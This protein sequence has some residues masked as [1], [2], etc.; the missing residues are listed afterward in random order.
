M[1]ST[2][3]LVVPFVK[4]H[5]A[6]NDFIVIDNRFMHFTG[7]ELATI[8]LRFCPR[9]FGIG[10]D[11]LLALEKADEP[12]FNYRMRYY[13]ADGSVARM[14]GNGARCLARFAYHGGVEGTSMTDGISYRFQSDAGSYSADVSFNSQ[15]DIALHVP[16]PEGFREDMDT[17]DLGAIHYIWTGTEHAVVMVSD[18]AT[19]PVAEFGSEIR[20]AVAFAPE[21]ANAD[22]VQ[23]AADQGDTAHLLVRTFERGVEAETLA[24]GT[25]VLASAVVAAL[26]GLSTA[27]HYTVDVPGGRL[28]VDIAWREGADRRR[29]TI[30]DIE[31]LTLSGPAATVYQGTLEFSGE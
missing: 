18:V 5:G 22:F 7:A 20:H 6:G 26:T 2:Q 8:A 9:R 1:K 13:N 12:G 31:G 11:G 4:M 14:C 15:G 24:C 3:P 16:P 27:Q 21:G 30:E 28:G 17:C 25:G 10:A 19:V 23:V 29:P